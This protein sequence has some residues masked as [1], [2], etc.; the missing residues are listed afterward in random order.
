MYVRFLTELLGN[1]KIDVIWQIRGCMMFIVDGC[2]VNDFLVSTRCGFLYW[3]L[4]C[5]GR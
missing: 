2:M 1:G 4:I 3:I 5:A